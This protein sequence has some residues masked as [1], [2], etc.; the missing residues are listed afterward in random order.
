MYEPVSNKVDFSESEQSVLEFWKENGTFLKSVEARKGADEFLFYDGPPFATGL[1]HYGHLL[2]GTIKDIVPRYQTMRGY[3]VDRRFGWDCHGLPVEF[4]VEQDLEISG[5]TQIEE[6]GVDVF[7]ERCRSIVLRYTSEWRSV[8][9][10]MGRWVDF[11]RDYK[12][13]DPSYME[14]IWWVFK[15]L[16]DKGLIYEGK[17][18]LPY[19]PRCSTPLSN[20]ETNQGYEDVT[21]PAITIRFK[22]KNEDNAYILAWTTTPW[23]LPSNMALAVGKDIV[24]ARIEDKGSVYYMAK[25][26]VSVYYRDEDEYDKMTELRGDELVGKTYEPIFPYFAHCSDEGAFRVLAADFVSTGDGTGVVHIAPGFGEDDYMLGMKEGLPAV[27]PV[28][29][30]GQFT[31]EVSDYAGRRVKEADA[32]I[33]KRLKAEGKLV[34]RSTIVHSYPHCWRCD[35]PLIYRGIS[36]WFVKVEQIKDRLVEANKEIKWV[37]GHL[38]DGRFGK[39]LEG[40]RDWAISRNRYWGA[41]LPVW[42]SEDGEEVLCVGSIAELEKLGGREVKDLHKHHVDKIEIPSKEGRGMLKRVPEVLDCWFESGSMPYAQAHYPF[43]NKDRFEAHFPADFIAEGLD[44]TRG[45]FYTL[46]VLSVALFDRPAFR[47][48]VVNGMVLAEDGRKMSKRLKNYPDAMYML[49][50][51]GADALRLYMINSP[52]VR[53]ED[54]RFSEDGVKHS[55]RHLLIPLW[56][57]YSFFVTYANIDGWSAGD[58][59][60]GVST[61]VLDRWIRSSLETLVAD[62]AT[63]MDGYD[64]QRSVR[65][66]VRFIEDLT[67]WYIRRSRRRFWKSQDDDDKSQAYQTLHHVLVQLSK[68]AAPFLPFISESIYRNLRS[69][70]SPESVHLCDFPIA[71][72]S[73]RDHTLEEAMS[74][75][76]TCVRLGRQLRSEHNLKVRQPLSVLHVVT[77]N[78][79]IID[80]IRELKDII[81]DELNVK[82]VAFGDHE[83]ELAT[84]SAKADFRQLGPRFGPKVKVVAKAISEIPSNELERIVEGDSVS[85]SVDGEEVELG[86]NDVV[87]ERIPHDGLVVACEG[88]ILVA[89]ETAL[90]DELVEEGLARELVNK[91]QNMRKEANLD[92]TQRIRVDVSG[93]EDIKRAVES[94]ME[95]VQTETLCVECSFPESSA[96]SEW[97]INGHPCRIEV[98][99]VQVEA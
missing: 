68:V 31:D 73:F 36:T 40:A 49:D 39:W 88:Q 16:W 72:G 58:G 50:T 22:L 84:L 69:E 41:P 89:I 76:M 11:D 32:D 7:N 37:P 33:M 99:P 4:E 1:P 60:S 94:N 62:V 28:D 83:T 29:A 79:E 48:V 65:P 19:C 74:L 53:A 47:N 46:M 54:L 59:S 52:V 45:W 2:A 61:N 20:F 63:A 70:G 25:D 13:M 3:Y 10:R 30:E 91:V 6:L 23:T 64:L 5:K 90:T 93:G 66:F 87:I 43:E 98:I 96:G 17:K 80:S 18:I 8:V 78:S 71:D 97:E 82:K 9:T 44:Q 12:T 77:R 75:V 86:P 38:K 95:Y 42:R 14:S 27:C 34:H 15:S 24:Y 26:R 51:Y 81:A 85:I 35:E 67:N 55:L 92:V 21:D 57:A 56:N